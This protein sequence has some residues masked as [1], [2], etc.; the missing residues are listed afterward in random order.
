MQYLCPDCRLLIKKPVI[1]TTVE[2]LI[3]PHC[4][5]YHEF[6]MTSP[7]TFFVKKPM[8]GRASEPVD[9]GVNLYYLESFNL[10]DLKE[11]LKRA[12]RIEDYEYCA[13]LRDRIKEL[14]CLESE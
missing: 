5:K 11:D 14:E 13:Q 12:E 6:E 7:T 3:C 4:G 8:R 9:S 2:L 10:N 1:V